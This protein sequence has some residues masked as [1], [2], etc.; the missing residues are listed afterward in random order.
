M[1]PD[2]D[3]T[4]NVE[5]NSSLRSDL[6]EGNFERPLNLI[7]SFLQRL[8]HHGAFKGKAL[9]LPTIDSYLIEIAD[10]L[11]AVNHRIQD[12]S[13]SE[14]YTDIVICSELYASGGH[15]R[16]LHELQTLDSR[17]DLILVTDVFRKY[18]NKAPDVD[19]PKGPSGTY[20][21]F[22]LLPNVSLINKLIM[23]R[24]ILSSVIPRSVLL[25]AHPQDV[26]AI[27]GALCLPKMV[28]VHFIHHVDFSP[29]IGAT[30]RQFNHIDLFHGTASICQTEQKFPN[31]ILPV[32]TKQRHLDISEK[33][34]RIVATGGPERKYS[35]TGE[36][37]LQRVIAKV[38][39]VLDCDFVLYGDF[40]ESALKI[41]RSYLDAT[42]IN[43][44]KFY[45]EGVVPDLCFTAIERG[46]SVYIDSFPFGGGTSC[47][48]M[49]SVGIPVLRYCSTKGSPLERA[50]Q[51]N[52]T[53]PALVWEYPE[54]IP[55]LIVF[56]WNNYISEASK[57]K[58]YFDIN[59]SK[60][61]FVE[62]SH[63]LG[64]AFQK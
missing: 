34:K 7:F 54:E 28:P 10:R 8:D 61:T 59:H 25:L 47:I 29:S 33:P 12:A 58:N 23:I 24:D 50:T 5:L 57:S 31:K 27:C 51:S 26:V 63:R 44:E 41:I 55:N 32:T 30:I 13:N 60:N 39:S 42:G 48:E 40:S 20:A 21:P 37:C 36:A 46:V 38:I 6:C 2:N 19:F 62:A 18:A 16:L 11:K 4:L 14:R 9:F 22:L 35:L 15:T 49:M 53:P 1:P 3:C 45:Y 56:S 64:L 17:R 43:M 52:L